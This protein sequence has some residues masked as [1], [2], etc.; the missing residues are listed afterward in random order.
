MLEQRERRL[1][2]VQLA[3]VRTKQFAAQRLFLVVNSL[4]LVLVLYTSLRFPDKFLRVTGECSSNWLRLGDAQEN[5]RVVC[6]EADNHE[7]P[8]HA[9]MS[10]APVLSSLQGAWVI[11][12]TPLIFNYC[13]MILGPNAN[14]FRVRVIVRRGLLYLT[15]MFLR[16]FVLY[17]SLNHVE[18][19]IVTMLTGAPHDHEC[20]YQPMRHGK[21]C[22]SRFDH[23][24]HLVLFISHFIG[25]MLFE[26][27]ALD[28]EIPTST[29]SSLKKMVL[30][31]WMLFLAGIVTYTMFFTSAYFHTPAENVV[32]VLIAQACFMY[33]LY[34]VT[35]DH[36]AARAWWL[37][38]KNFVL[39]PDDRKTR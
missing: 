16:T 12:L 2:P 39:P 10:L 36:F 11:P 24:D 20:W 13:A 8:C 33:P 19:W 9:G 23:S 18:T 22:A 15:L 17:V 28:V 5:H 35:Q 34:L 38:L 7:A 27:F 37:R 1:S 32:A 30:R 25:I 26:W 3:I 6:C 14:I 29:W 4:L 31:G 21:R